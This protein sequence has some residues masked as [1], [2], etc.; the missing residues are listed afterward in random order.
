M[1]K[2]V[3]EG[4]APP[5]SLY[6]RLQDGTL[7]PAASVVFPS[8]PGVRPLP[9]IARVMIAPN[10]RIPRGY[11]PYIDRTLALLV[12]AVDQDGNERA[13]IR[14]PEIAVPL[15]TYTG[16]NLRK[17]SLRASDDLAPLL[18]STITFPA[19]RADREKTNDPRASVEERYKS[20][21]EYLARVE[22]ALDALVLK[23]YL[24]YDDGP[25]ILQ[26][27]GDQWDLIVD[28]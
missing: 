6:P 24:I 13:G 20:R 19:T 10:P 25:R 14:L 21:D 22:Q 26:R 28:R 15:A 27:A 17:P 2:W 8:I 1:H 12:P 7:V 11:N 5:P 16:W 9:G 4:I 18:G 3:K 23:G